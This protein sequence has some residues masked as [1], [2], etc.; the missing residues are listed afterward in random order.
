MMILL[1]SC[2][3]MTQKNTIVLMKAI[4]V[5]FLIIVRVFGSVDLLLVLK[6]LRTAQ[7]VQMLIIKMIRKKKMHWDRKSIMKIVRFGSLGFPGTN[8]LVSL[9]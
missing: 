4:V 8:S 5:K 6:W 7:M 3:T 1:R 2:Q 9:L